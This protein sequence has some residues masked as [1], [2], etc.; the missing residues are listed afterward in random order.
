M[1]KTV[2]IV[3]MSLIFS[4]PTTAAK[5]APKQGIS[6]EISVNALFLSSTSNFNTDGEK[7]LTSINHS[8]NSE[9]NFVIA[10][11]GNIAYTFGKRSEQ[12]LFIGTTRS[13]V[14]VGTLAFELGY[15]YQ[16]ASGTA[17]S[18]T[19]IPTVMSGKTWTD[20]YQVGTK[21]KETDESGNAYRLRLENIQGS[22]LSLDFAYATKDIDNEQITRS[23]LLRDAES[24]YLKGQYRL[25]L[26]RTMILMPALTYI[27]HQ[28]DGN[29]NSYQ[30]Y[31]LDLSYF[32]VMG[33]HQLVFTAGYTYRDY[34][35]KNSLY[36]NTVRSDD[37]FSLFAA[38]EYDQLMGWQNWSLI[39]LA[40]YGN[41]NSNITFYD[42]SQ[43]FTSVGINFKF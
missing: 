18:F 37:E 25:M 15:K 39:S 20:P 4:L 41:S 8:A 33:R 3:I 23:E 43:L 22:P 35:G 24:Y 17:V 16:F 42:E 1:K 26:S 27:D 21:R 28:A 31:A 34:D 40:G 11:L 30:S 14:A 13:D 5:P 36:N 2:P 12:Q 32:Q 9:S 19:Y 6:G 38:Y 10:P 29:A 7:V